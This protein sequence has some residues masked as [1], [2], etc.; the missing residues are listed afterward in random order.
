[1]IPLLTGVNTALFFG[2]FR[3]A[4]P[5]GAAAPTA[6]ALAFTV[7]LFASI[8]FLYRPVLFLVVNAL[9]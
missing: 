4:Y 8:L 1:M 3:R 6:K 9:T 7:L 5:E 2:M